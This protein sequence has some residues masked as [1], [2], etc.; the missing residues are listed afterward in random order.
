[1]VPSFSLLEAVPLG[2]TIVRT[3]LI[4]TVLL[5]AIHLA[6][7]QS[8]TR[9]PGPVG[10]PLVGNVFDL[11]GSREAENI[12][13]LGSKY[14]EAPLAVSSSNILLIQTQETSYI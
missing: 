14:G 8:K 3:L 10:L 9:P 1:M 12:A 11:P 5:W 13:A 6:R 4:A 2:L 7:R